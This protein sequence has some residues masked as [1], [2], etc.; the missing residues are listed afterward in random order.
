MSYLEVLQNQDRD[1]FGILDLGALEYLYGKNTPA[2]GDN[3][4]SYT[5][6]IGFNLTLIND[7][8]GT[9]T[10]DLSNVTIG[11]TLDMNPGA[12]SSI[13][14]SDPDILAINSLAIAQSVIIENAIGTP[15]SDSITGNSSNNQLR[16][17][18]GDDTLIG[19]AGT[20]TAIF[21]GPKSA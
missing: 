4:Y 13:G 18:A 20:D 5:D 14:L 19:G 6:E 8:G 16:G 9:D 7:A 3:T 15:A 2:T 11:A 12:F 17:G 10:I 1:W 21:S